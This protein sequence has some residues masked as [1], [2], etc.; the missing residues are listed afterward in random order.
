MI[1]LSHNLLQHAMS[2]IPKNWGL[3]PWVVLNFDRNS[4]MFVI[5]IYMW[6]HCRICVLNATL[7]IYPQYTL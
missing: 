4:H 5:R 6:V 7:I 2:G 3:A 1:F